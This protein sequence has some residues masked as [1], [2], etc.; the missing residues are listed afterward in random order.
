MLREVEEMK[1]GLKERLASVRTK[2][3][4]TPAEYLAYPQKVCWAEWKGIIE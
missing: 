2:S 1:V 3:Q 4:Q